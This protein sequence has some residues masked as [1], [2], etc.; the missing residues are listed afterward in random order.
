MRDWIIRI[1]LFRVVVLITLLSIIASVIISVVTSSLAGR[2]FSYTSILI[3]IIVPAIISPIATTFIMSMVIKTHKLEMEMREIAA[4]LQKSN[5]AKSEFLANMSHEIRTPLNGALSMIRLLER[6]DLTAEQHEYVDAINFSSNTLLTII[7]D[8]LDLSIIEAGKLQLESVRFEL[9]PLLENMVTLLLPKAVKHNNSLNYHVDENIHEVLVG[10]PT[11]LRQLLFNLIGN[12]LKFTDN[13]TVSI[14]V[15]QIDVNNNRGK[16][17]LLFEVVDTG[18]GICDEIK[19]KLFES[20]TQAD[21][22]INRRFGGSGLGLTICKHI[23]DAMGGEFDFSSREG[24]GS[25]FWFKIDLPYSSK[26]LTTTKEEVLR[27]SSESTGLNIL[28]VEDDLINQRAESALLKKDGHQIT[29]ANDGYMALD[30]L[31]KIKTD[32]LTPFDLIFM[33]IRMPG[34]NGMETT[35]HI[36]QMAGP[37]STLPIIALTADVT[38]QNIEAC[39]AAGIDQVIS[40]PIR[41]S[42]LTDV[43]HSIMSGESG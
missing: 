13:G 22:S 40:K 26:K 8:V 19:Q 34:L 10:D 4:K 12:A 1:G 41:Y 18:I 29:V 28:L 17:S 25:T 42:E 6:T 24:E 3:S 21:S 16:E 30:I 15:T 5:D 37:I 38:Q 36:R 14:K 7:S 33:D 20:F 9:K 39:L 2:E 23:V 35:Q 11:R 32:K 43:L 27:D 31:G